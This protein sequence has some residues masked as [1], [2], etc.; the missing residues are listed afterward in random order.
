M[1]QRNTIATRLAGYLHSKGIPKDI[2]LEMLREFG[3]RCDPPMD[4]PELE[5][6]IQS[7]TRYQ[8]A[9]TAA[10]VVDPPEF[11]D[12]G[13]SQ[14]YR[15]PT[16]GVE[17]TLSKVTAVKEGVASEITITAQVPGEP[18][19]RSGPD[20]LNLL[21]TT[22]KVSLIRSLKT[23]IDLDWASI[24]ETVAQLAVAQLRQ[25]SPLLDLAE[26]A[27]RPGEKWL[28]PP[29][30]LDGQPTILFGDGGTGKSLFA[31]DA[32]VAIQFGQPNALGMSPTAQ[33]KGLYLDWEFDHWE[34]GDRLAKLLRG[35]E[36]E[37]GQ[38]LYLREIGPLVDDV[39]RLQR[40][41]HD[42]GIGFIVIDSAAPACGGEGPEKA[43]SALRFFNS[44]RALKTTCLIVAHQ[45]KDD[46]TNKPFGSVFFHNMSRATWEVKAHQR[47]EG[48]LEVALTNRKSNSGR[49]HD[50][51]AY[52]VTFGEESITL[53]RTSITETEQLKD[54][55]PIR[56]RIKALLLRE[57]P[58]TTA[59]IGDELEI[60]ENTARH[61]LERNGLSFVRL[62]QAPPHE[63]A[64]VTTSA[65]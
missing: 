23:R 34:H 35:L 30:V 6:T 1:S 55:A 10:R 8:Q 29:V 61:T 9:A 20:N 13:S 52:V 53:K 19:V 58:M 47:G 54:E 24:I 25:G 32:L 45:S 2:I 37:N 62:T 59:Q 51:L 31:L 14:L 56:L 49:L 5:R 4:E 63:W 36:C 11:E 48:P 50:P 42:E 3:A 60:P 65:P 27:N 12:R 40:I 17:V 64:V 43:D 41:I 44:I 16:W 38:V 39:S 28:L 7:V 18:P 26:Y 21:A 33:R 46:K 22:S 57:G 15:W